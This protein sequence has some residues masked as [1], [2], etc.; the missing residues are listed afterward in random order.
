MKKENETKIMNFPKYVQEK[1][2]PK[3]V[4]RSRLRGRGST[5]LLLRNPDRLES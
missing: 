1:K 2:T 5:N 3:G 4:Q